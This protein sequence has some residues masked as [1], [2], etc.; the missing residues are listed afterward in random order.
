[1]SGSVYHGY[2]GVRTWMHEIDEQFGTWR[3]QLDEFAHVTGERLLVLGSIC[4]RGRRS[5]I[6]LEV[7][8]GWLYEFRGARILRL[9][10]YATHEEG[11]RAAGVG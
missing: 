3:T 2:D 5:G 11:R 9:S 4:F 1:M 8:I 10:T 7:P 6:E